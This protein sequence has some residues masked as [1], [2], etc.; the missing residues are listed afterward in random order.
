MILEYYHVCMLYE[1]NA[2]L[3]LLLFAN[4]NHS[5]EGTKA[6]GFE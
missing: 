4:Q 2:Y 6:C 5:G 1:G 3:F